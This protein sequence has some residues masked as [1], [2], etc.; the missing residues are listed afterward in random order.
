MDIEDVEVVR[1]ERD[2]SPERFA[3]YD[4]RDGFRRNYSQLGPDQRLALSR[5]VTEAGANSSDSESDSSVELQEIRSSNAPRAQAAGTDTS[6]PSLTRTRTE[7]ERIN[8]HERHPKALERIETHRTQHSHTIGGGITRRT[9]TVKSKPLP[10]FGAGK[11][12]PPPLPA[13]EEYVV[14]Y[15]GHDVS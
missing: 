3:S 5:Q 11:P 7:T 4:P 10:N 2:A 13:Q 1:A 6:T 8:R 14:E 15:D 12:Y 9:S